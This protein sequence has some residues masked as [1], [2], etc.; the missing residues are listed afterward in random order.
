MRYC[1]ALDDGISE[2][3]SLWPD[4]PPNYNPY[5]KWPC[6]VLRG[7]GAV[8]GY[9]TCDPVPNWSEDIAAAWELGEEFPEW[10]AGKYPSG[11]RFIGWDYRDGELYK[12][13]EEYGQSIEIAICRAY[14]MWKQG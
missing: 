7:T 8:E 12:A 5:F 13:A 14:L 2:I 11:Y 3:Q 4:Q 6:F 1:G 10:S 9:V